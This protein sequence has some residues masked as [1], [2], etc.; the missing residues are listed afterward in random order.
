M[1]PIKF[2]TRPC[3]AKSL[4][5]VALSGREWV[6]TRQLDFLIFNTTTDASNLLHDLEDLGLE[7]SVRHFVRAGDH[8]LLDLRPL[9]ADFNAMRR[10]EIDPMAGPAR[11][12]SLMPAKT[13]VTVALHRHR[14]DVL[15]ALGGQVPEEW[16]REH[17]LAEAEASGEVLGTDLLPEED[18]LDRELG[19]DELLQ[20]ALLSSEMLDCVNDDEEENDIGRN[21]ALTELSAVL[22]GQL[23]D[24]AQYRTRVLVASRHGRR[25][26]EITLKNDR[27]VL[28]R[29]LGWLKT[30][31]GP[32]G[33][34]DLTAFGRGDAAAQVEA[35]VQ[36]CHEDRGLAFGT[37]A[38]YT[39]SLLSVAQ[40]ANT[41]AEVADATLDA[42]L[43]L[44]RQCEG[45]AKEQNKYRARHKEW[46]SWSELQTTREN[47]IL[48]LEARLSHAAKLQLLEDVCIIG[49]YTTAPPDRVGG[50]A[51][52]IT[53]Q[54]WPQ[55]SFASSSSGTR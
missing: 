19:A 1:N 54:L 13:A 46:M 17:R 7:T 51:P 39:N 44:R 52:P 6:Y 34:L 48:A 33:A 30:Q 50:T 25:V 23:A 12:C 16:E 4:R 47:A 53:T 20:C 49:L 9:L 22:E 55:A 35:Y 21:Y 45:E 28:L 36:W 27:G 40:F 43:N 3:G 26:Q 31:D 14:R 38:G 15:P 10:A 37:I 24:L 11:R 5:L 41:V 18:E 42:L 29:F 32:A 2:E 8:G